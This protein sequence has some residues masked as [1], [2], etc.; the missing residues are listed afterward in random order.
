MSTVCLDSNTHL[1]YQQDLSS[2]LEALTCG[3]MQNN[4]W[5]RCLIKQEE[6]GSSILVMV[7]SMVP[8][9]ISRSRIALEDCTSLELFSWTLTFLRDLICSTKLVKIMRMMHNT[10]NKSIRKL[11]KINMIAVVLNTCKES[12]LK[13]SFILSQKSSRQDLKDHSLFIEPFLDQ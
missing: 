2:I 3:T 1:S 5:K 4:S 10:I 12:L 7:P 11:S 13:K 9:L 8:R 6:N